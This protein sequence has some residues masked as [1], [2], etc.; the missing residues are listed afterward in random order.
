[1]SGNRQLT[2]RDLAINST[3]RAPIPNINTP[4]SPMMEEM[5]LTNV[6]QAAERHGGRSWK[7]YPKKHS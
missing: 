4:G 2:R 7:N 5:N 1:M 6:S 3:S